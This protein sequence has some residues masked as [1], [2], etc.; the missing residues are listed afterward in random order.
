MTLPFLSPANQPV[1]SSVWNQNAMNTTNVLGLVLGTFSLKKCQLT[2]LGTLQSK[3][4]LNANHL[5]TGFRMTIAL[6]RL[7]SCQSLASKL[8]S[9]RTIDLP[10]WPEHVSISRVSNYQLAIWRG[11]VDTNWQHQILCW[12]IYTIAMGSSSGCLIW[13]T[14]QF[15][16]TTN[17][18]H[19]MCCGGIMYPTSTNHMNSMKARRV[20]NR[21]PWVLRK[22]C[23][24]G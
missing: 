15:G 5:K 11:K 13:K 2:A 6:Q 20:L 4:A 3:V 23:Q 21:K 12:T 24:V 7:W 9:I 22:L 16:V 18:Y 10:R 19:R 14:V 8:V 1:D 17:S